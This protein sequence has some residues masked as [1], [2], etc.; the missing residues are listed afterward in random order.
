LIP[1][2]VSFLLNNPIDFPLNQ[3]PQFKFDIV[4]EGL[5]YPVFLESINIHSLSPYFQLHGF[6]SHAAA[7]ECI[8]GSQFSLLPTLAPTDG[9]DFIGSPTKLFEYMAL[10][11]IPIASNVGQQSRILNQSVQPSSFISSSFSTPPLD[12]CGIIFQHDS[13]CSLARA[14]YYAI[15][16]YQ[17][18]DFM[19][20]NCRARVE[21]LYTWQRHVRHLLS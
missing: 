12:C 11:S 5:Q 18:L 9:S 7:L 14:I 19:R 8:S 20:H 2:A 21:N 16:N 4:G 17:S 1:E 6:L 10:G 13:V 3:L 15:A